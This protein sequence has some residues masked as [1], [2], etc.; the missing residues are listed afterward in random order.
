MIVIAG[1]Q[2]TLRTYATPD[3]SSAPVVRVDASQTGQF[4]AQMQRKPV[5]APPKIYIRDLLDLLQPVV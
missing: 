3:N 4:Q 5:F 2:L 1:D